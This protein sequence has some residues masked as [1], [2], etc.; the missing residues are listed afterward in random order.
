MNQTITLNKKNNIRE[1]VALA[2]GEVYFDIKAKQYC[3][4]LKPTFLWWFTNRK[5][6]ITKDDIKRQCEVVYY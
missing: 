5:I 2:K 4:I 3:L 1:Q 6:L